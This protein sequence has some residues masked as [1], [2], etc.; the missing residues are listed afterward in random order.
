MVAEH[1]RD[2][3]NRYRAKEISAEQV[4]SSLEP[5]PKRINYPSDSWVRMW[6]SCW[7]WS[8]LT[9]SSDDSS[10]LPYTHSDMQTAR[11]EVN[12]LVSEHG[13]HRYLLLNYDQVWRNAWSLTKT[14]LC[15]KQRS[16]AGKRIKK[17]R[18]GTRIDKKIHAIRGSRRSLTDPRLL[19]YVGT[20]A[21]IHVNLPELFLELFWNP[22]RWYNYVQLQF[23][24]YTVPNSTIYLDTGEKRLASYVLGI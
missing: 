6:K 23:F 21:C 4:L 19:L 1:N 12:K 18:V 17:A 22:S 16:G 20:R 13:C 9:R 8:M 14:P 5:E 24:H 11:D 2:V 3:E 15:Y 10:W 7:G